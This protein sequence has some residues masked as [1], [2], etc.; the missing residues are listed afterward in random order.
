VIEATTVRTAVLRVLRRGCDHYVNARCYARVCQ[1]GRIADDVVAIVAE[2]GRKE[3]RTNAVPA[4]SPVEDEP[5]PGPTPRRGNHQMKRCE[6]THCTTT[7]AYRIEKIGGGGA[8]G[9]GIILAR[10][11]CIDHAAQLAR[12]TRECLTMTPLPWLAAEHGTPR[13]SPF[14]DHQLGLGI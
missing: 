7:A 1:C 9:M 2:G 13:T 11:Y 8:A 4:P 12:E 3:P 5:V 6:T 14:A 10:F